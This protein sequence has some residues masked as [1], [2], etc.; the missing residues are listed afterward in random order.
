MT[1]ELVDIG[2]NLTDRAFSEDLKKVIEDAA[3]HH[4]TKLIVTGT[5]LKESSQAIELCQHFPSQTYCTVG[6][7]PH[8]A[9]EWTDSHFQQLQKLS[10]EPAVVAIGETGLDFNRN[11]S[12]PLQQLFAFEQQLRLAAETGRPLFLHERDA[13]E[14]QIKLL[15]QYQNHISGGVIHCFTGSQQELDNYLELDLYI[16]ITGWICDERRGLHLQ[17]LVHK[18]PKSRLLIETD[19][20]Y[21]LPR[22]LRPKPKSRRNEPKYLAHINQ[23]IS[24]LLNIEESE[25]AIQTTLNAKALFGLN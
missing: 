19:S 9:K 23:Y 16:G 6:V 10:L 3:Q 8:N 25:L 14:E 12:P 11:F 4:T 18:I 15:R 7:H 21:L 2:V 24:Q 20:P 1:F 17:E 22:T 13:H 5:S